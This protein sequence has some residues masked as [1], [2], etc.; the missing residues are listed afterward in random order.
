MIKKMVC[1]PGRE[2]WPLHLTFE[3]FVISMDY[4]YIAATEPYHLNGRV[5]LYQFDEGKQQFILL[6]MIQSPSFQAPQDPLPGFGMACLVHDGFVFIMD[7]TRPFYRG[8]LYVFSIESV[9]LKLLYEPPAGSCLLASMFSSRRNDL[10]HYFIRFTM[11]NKTTH[12]QNI[13][14]VE[15]SLRKPAGH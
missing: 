10:N 14:E 11:Y 1:F 15:Y 6:H 9:E 5:W 7:T 4:P 8:S 3:P 12:E 13:H 2:E